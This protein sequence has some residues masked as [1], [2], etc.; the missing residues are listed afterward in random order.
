MQDF[1]FIKDTHSRNLVIN[2][3]HAVSRC[4][5]WDFL[6]NFTPN[7]NDG[8]MFTNHPK[9][10][11]IGNMMESCPHPPGHSGCSFAWTMRQLE[12]IAKDGYEDYK[13]SWIRRYREEDE[14]RRTRL[15]QEVALRNNLVPE[16]PPILIINENPEVAPEIPQQ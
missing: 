16:I 3:H 7:N 10:Y 15:A 2:G 11:E 8:F 4:E 14:E 9:V 6:K 1:T 12:S 5:A 13:N